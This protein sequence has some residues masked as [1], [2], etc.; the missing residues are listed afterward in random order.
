MSNE[1]LLKMLHEFRDERDWNQFH[2]VGRLIRS[3]A[4]EAGELLE[5]VQWLTDEQ[6][7]AQA[8]SSPLKQ[9]LLT[10]FWA[11]PA[12]FTVWVAVTRVSA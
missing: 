2:D 9:R 5:A 4:I 12:R 6:I 8:A 10:H 1:Q 11:R 7:S 3:V